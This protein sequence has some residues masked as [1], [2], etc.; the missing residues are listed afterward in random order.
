MKDTNK[1][2]TDL[3]K[4][5]QRHCKVC[6]AMAFNV[7]ATCP[8]DEKLHADELIAVFMKTDMTAIVFGTKGTPY[9]DDAKQVRKFAVEHGMRPDDVVL[10]ATSEYMEARS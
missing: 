5:I 8:C 2:I 7:V 3:K 1:K 4:L 9:E 6:K 10:H